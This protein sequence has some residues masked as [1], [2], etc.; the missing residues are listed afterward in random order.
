MADAI[1]IL[2]FL[3]VSLELLVQ[4]K[5]GL[6]LD[7]IDR[8]SCCTSKESL[9]YTLFSFLPSFFPRVTL[10]Y[11]AARNLLTIDR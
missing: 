8:D 11:H 7:E 10:I 6:N 3:C 5:E 1:L 9:Y 4:S 2:F